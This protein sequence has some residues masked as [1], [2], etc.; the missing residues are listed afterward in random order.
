MTN[1]ESGQETVKSHYE[2]VRVVPLPVLVFDDG[3][4]MRVG[5]GITTVIDLGRWVKKVSD[6]Y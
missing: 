3:S 6:L 1:I 2:T 4:G 5:R